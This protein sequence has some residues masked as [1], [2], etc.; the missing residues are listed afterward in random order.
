[1]IKWNEW[2]EGDIVMV[3]GMWISVG[4]S[5]NEEA[6]AGGVM[7]TASL[8]R[9]ATSTDQID[10]TTNIDFAKLKLALD[11]GTKDEDLTDETIEVNG[12]ITGKIV[13]EYYEVYLIKGKTETVNNVTKTHGTLLFVA[14]KPWEER[15]PS[16]LTISSDL[17]QYD[18]NIVQRNS[19]PQDWI[20]GGDQKE[21]LN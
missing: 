16:L 8:W 5:R 20:D 11:G 18:I 7:K 19:S 13:N 15:E 2:E 21:D 3:E 6:R 12:T 10:F 1:V 9:N 4:K 17:I 14:K